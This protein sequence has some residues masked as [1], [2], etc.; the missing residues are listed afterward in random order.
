MKDA[1]R[2]FACFW[3]YVAYRLFWLASGDR[4][5]LLSLRLYARS[6]HDED[7]VTGVMA[8]ILLGMAIH[9]KISP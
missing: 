5:P 8:W 9:W 2:M 1:P 7:A 6:T 3:P 4:T